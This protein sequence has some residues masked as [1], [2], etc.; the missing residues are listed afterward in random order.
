MGYGW[1]RWVSLAGGIFM[2]MGLFAHDVYQFF[3]YEPALM[4]VIDRIAAPVNAVPV[5]PDVRP[6]LTL[7]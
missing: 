2:I 6:L 3:F 4:R 5:G 7:P 1:G